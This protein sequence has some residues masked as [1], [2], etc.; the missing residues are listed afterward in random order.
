MR[1]TRRQFLAATG[2]E[3]LLP[4]RWFRREPSIAGI[5]FR[6]VRRDEGRHYIWIHG[7]EQTA[8]GVLSDW[9]RTATG[10]AFFIRSA[11]RN[12]EVEGGKIDPNRMWSRVGAERSLRSLNPGWTDAG[13]RAAL[14]KLDDDREGFLRRI[15]PPPN[16]LLIALHNNGPAYSVRD[17]VS[18]SDA[19]ALTDPDHPDEFMLCTNRPDFELLAGGPFNVLLQ[20]QAPP[21]DDG[22]L[23]RLCAAR[24]IRYVNI[25]AAHGNAEAQHR[26]LEWL[27]GVLL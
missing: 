4:W 16:G 7:D 27:N 8:R 1:P 20:R 24:N 3:L 25:E 17:E 13:V 15:V 6:E 12:V 22:S 23:S 2:L 21:E 19:V 5:R 11:E 14:D 10:R 9:M 18:I 26:M